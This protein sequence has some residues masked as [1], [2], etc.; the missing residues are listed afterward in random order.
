MGYLGSF[1]NYSSIEMVLVLAI[2]VFARTGFG[3][4]GIL[5]IIHHE[6]IFFKILKIFF[7]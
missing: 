6:N 2:Y 7:L 1:K 3:V 4:E 5:L